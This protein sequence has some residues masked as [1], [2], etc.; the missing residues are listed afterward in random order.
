MCVSVSITDH[1]DERTDTQ[2]TL[3]KP[4]PNISV[5]FVQEAVFY[6]LKRERVDIV[7]TAVIKQSSTIP[8]DAWFVHETAVTT[9]DLRSTLLTPEINPYTSAMSQLF[10]KI[11]GVSGSLSI[12]NTQK[13]SFTDSNCEG[14][15]MEIPGRECDKGS[16]S[17]AP[18]VCVGFGPLVCSEN[19][20]AQVLR[21]GIHITGKAFTR[22]IHRIN[23]TGQ[24]FFGI[25]G[26]G[27][28][29]E[30][31]WYSHLPGSPKDIR[32]IYTPVFDRVVNACHLPIKTYQVLT[33]DTANAENSIRYN[34]G[35][36][37]AR[38]LRENYTFTTLEL[39][40]QVVN[41]WESDSERFV[42]L[43]GSILD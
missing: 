13:Y 5:P 25:N 7:I 39:G 37:E 4:V 35:L 32:K 12:E 34:R 19:T 11:T 15:F 2:H 27:I 14:E 42:I 38:L 26:P 6:A 41:A 24:Y 43:R 23:G 22:L 21:F 40:D 16:R 1:L 29:L 30:D 36:A 28:V 8:I 9:N 18:F 20:V 17:D 31:I 10:E 3:F 33:F